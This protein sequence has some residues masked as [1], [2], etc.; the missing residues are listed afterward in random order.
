ML[1]NNQCD[2]GSMH[3]FYYPDLYKDNKRIRRETY[4]NSLDQPRVELIVI[5]NGGHNW[6]MEDAYNNEVIINFFSRHSKK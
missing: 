3:L 6:F 5:E 4:Y 2:P 1:E